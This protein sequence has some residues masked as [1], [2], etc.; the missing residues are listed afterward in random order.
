MY[1]ISSGQVS[2]GI[3]LSHDSMYVS[4]G[5]TANSTT[6]NDS[7]YLYVS[8]GG[9]A[10]ETTVNDN[11]QMY[12][13][14]GASAL[15]IRENGGYVDVAD[16]ASV[17]FVANSFSGLLL[18]HRAT[19]HSG[20]TAN[21]TT[22]SGMIVSSG[23]NWFV[24]CMGSLYISSGGTANNTVVNTSGFVFVSSGGT[25]NNTMVNSGGIN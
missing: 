6:V 1:R 16:G 2:S 5:G 10:N 19:L 24:T 15:T 8:S 11:G 14:N 21:E 3:T 23:T 25:A 12:V 9:T 7:G 20:T 22:L 4:S 17:S 13:F 18:F